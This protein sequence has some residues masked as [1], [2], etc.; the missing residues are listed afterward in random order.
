MLTKAFILYHGLTHSLQSYCGCYKKI[1][2]RSTKLFCHYLNK[3]KYKSNLSLIQKGS[4]GVAFE[5]EYVLCKSTI[6]LIKQSFYRTSY[7]SCFWKYNPQWISHLECRVCK[8]KRKKERKYYKRNICGKQT[9]VVSESLR[10][11]ICSVA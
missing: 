2:P 9:T 7:M 4:K 11:G 6:T 1:F 8:N 10:A 3:I 5:F